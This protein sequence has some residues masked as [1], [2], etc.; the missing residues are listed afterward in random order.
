V[1]KRATQ[2]LAPPPSV[3]LALQGGMLAARGTATHEWIAAARILARGMAG[4]DGLDSA[5]LEDSDQSE[6][7]RL[8]RK[9]ESRAFGF[10]LGQAEFWTSQRKELTELV[11]E[12]STFRR[13]ARRLGADVQVEIDGSVASAVDEATALAAGFSLAQR[14]LDAIKGLNADTSLFACRGVKHQAAGTPPYEAR[15]TLR[16]LVLD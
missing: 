14:F 11:G 15:V 12:V 7:G 4:V 1:L 9:I 8:R 13:V 5:A 3:T 10:R 16:V 2:V 6:L